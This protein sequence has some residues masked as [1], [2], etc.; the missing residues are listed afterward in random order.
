MVGRHRI[1]VARGD[2]GGDR[3]K[4]RLTIAFR[5]DYLRGMGI[6]GALARVRA[7]RSE[8]GWSRARLAAAAG[9]QDTV[10]RHLDE[11][12]WNPTAETVRRLEAVIPPGWAP[13]AQASRDDA[14]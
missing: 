3:V 13:V 10:L 7:Y 8:M 4:M 2:P 5:C 9:I 1:A 11:E 6:D 14:A 12:G